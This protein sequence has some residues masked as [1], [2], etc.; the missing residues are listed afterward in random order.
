VNSEAKSGWASSTEGLATI[1]AVS[2]AAVLIVIALATAKRS[3][4]VLEESTLS[5]GGGENSAQ[6][7]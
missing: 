7:E 3:T 1:I 4:S 2:V 6:T 5:F